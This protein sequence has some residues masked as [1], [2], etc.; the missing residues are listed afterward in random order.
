M[1]GLSGMDMLRILTTKKPTLPVISVSR[2]ADVDTA[3]AFQQA[4]ARD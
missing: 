2:A 3:L 1:P 4:G